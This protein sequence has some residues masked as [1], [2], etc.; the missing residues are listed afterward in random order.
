MILSN[1]NILG[2][3]LDLTLP[4]GATGLIGI[5]SPSSTDNAIVRWDGA[6]GDLVQNSVVTIA[7]TSGNLTIATA[8]ATVTLG[9]ATETLTVAATAAGAGTITTKAG[10]NL[11]I[12]NGTSG[13]VLATGTGSHVFGTTNTV[14][15]AAGALTATS[16]L[17]ST[18]LIIGTSGPSV[19]SSLAARF[20]QAFNFDGTSGGAI[21][22][23]IADGTGAF[24]W[25]IPI[26]PTSFAAARY[27]IGGAADSFA[28]FIH[29]D[30]TLKA[31]KVGTA[32]LTA[33]TTALTAGKA[34]RV[35]YSKTGTTGTYWINGVAAGTTTDNNDY[36]AIST[37]FG[38]VT[39]ATTTPF[40]GTMWRPIHENRA[41]TA[42]EVLALA[43]TGVPAASDYNSASNTAINTDTAV[44]ITYLYTSFTG[45]S[46][47]GFTAEKVGSGTAIAQL[48]PLRSAPIGTKYLL[49]FT[50]TLTSG[51]VPS[52]EL[53]D[54]GFNTKSNTHTVTAGANSVILTSTGA[55]DRVC[56]VTTEATSY[57]ISGAAWTPLGLLLAPDALEPGV[58][59]QWH[60]QSGNR[61]DITVPASGVV[62]SQPGGRG[63]Y[64]R[65]SAAWSATHAASASL[66]TL[67]STAVVTN[68][69]VEATFATSG[70]GLSVGTSDEAAKWKAAGAISA[71]TKTVCTLAAALPTSS[72]ATDLDVKIDPDDANVTGTAYL[73]MHYIVTSTAAP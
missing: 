25:E 38:S 54:S 4:P 50:A 6:T 64:I 41:L 68:L 57:A 9:A 73:D 18:D 67:P 35:G 34:A 22:N 19:K 56:F 21:V 39:N 71:D 51:E 45:A 27:I 69:I 11:T 66:G 53:E 58:G 52:V 12:A 40:L 63:N 13:G 70:A 49:T 29:T 17:T 28:F 16:T 60:D 48:A 32:A 37:L 20:G 7:D 15:M 43:E 47:T 14:T 65:G 46:A 24:F 72:D 2:G 42:A 44:N 10:Q 3:D 33:S 59:Y 62:W 55:A 23:G 8:T 26:L 30:G 5:A 31:Q 36:T 1:P 61:A